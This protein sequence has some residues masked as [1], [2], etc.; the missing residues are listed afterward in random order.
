MENRFKVK[1]ND[2]LSYNLIKLV[3]S[4]YFVVTIFITAGQMFAEFVSAKKEL[5]T[6]FKSY[7]R[8]LASVIYSEDMENVHVMI[9]GMLS[10]PGV[11]GVQTDTEIIRMGE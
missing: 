1:W 8:G 7:E 5:K 4:F 10:L 11:I 9:G 3:F 6:F 2:S